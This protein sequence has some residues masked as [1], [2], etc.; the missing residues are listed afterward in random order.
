MTMSLP[1]S[2]GPAGTLRSRKRAATSL[3]IRRAAIALALDHGYE[4]VTVE[5]ICEA[6]MV[7]QRTFFNYFGSREGVYLSAE[8]ALPSAELVAGFVEG[9]GSSVF[10]DLF[11]MIAGTVVDSDANLELFRA[12]HQ[13]IH[14]TPELLN[15]EKVRISEAE[16][17]FVGY[18]MARYL[19][20][21]RSVAATP[22][23]ED[24]ARM[25]VSL[26]SG[27]MRY[28]MQKWV[29]GNFTQTREDLVRGASE[30]IQ[31]ITVNEHWP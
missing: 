8:K 31:R 14:Q 22:D 25:V 2:S 21:G 30:L 10:G 18:V 9:T 17:S 26:V 28:A 24:E 11:N 29:A 1:A 15:Q 16:E 4:N 27:A 20:Q 5:M 19:F 23:L 7:S 6:S 13:L 12:R 3:A